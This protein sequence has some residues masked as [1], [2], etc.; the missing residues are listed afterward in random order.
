MTVQEL[1]AALQATPFRP[2]IIHIADGRSFEVRHHDF[3]L[4]GPNSRPAFVLSL[5]G[6][7]FSILD[8][9]LM[10]EIDFGQHGAQSTTNVSQPR[11]W[12]RTRRSAGRIL[13]E[14]APNQALQPTPR[15]EGL[16]TAQLGFPV[17]YSNCRE[18]A[19]LGR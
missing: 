11:T 7:A 10:T 9:M 16:S 17:G 12:L 6:M 14:S 3:L 18:A 8:A 19:E 4:L 2:F 13:P 15:W 1:H 5:S